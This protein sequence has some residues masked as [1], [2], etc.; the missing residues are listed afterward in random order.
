MSLSSKNNQDDNYS[1]LCS[2][3]D[4][5]VDADVSRTTVISK[6]EVHIP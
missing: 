5:N 2:S 1:N 6:I 4:N 3:D